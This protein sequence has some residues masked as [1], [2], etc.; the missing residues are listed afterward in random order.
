MPA[1]N[2]IELKAIQDALEAEYPLYWERHSRDFELHAITYT[3]INGSMRTR[4]LWT[5]PVYTL[6]DMH[7]VRMLYTE[8]CQ[9]GVAINKNEFERLVRGFDDTFKCMD[10]EFVLRRVL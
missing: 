5:K 6:D 4:K 9:G 1:K 3:W 7:E 8:L 10:G 2:P